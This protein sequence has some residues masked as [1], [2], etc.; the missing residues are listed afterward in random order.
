MQA[1]LDEYERANRFGFS[2][3]EVATAKSEAQSGA[4]SQFDSSDTTQDADYAT[5]YVANFLTG[6]AYPAADDAHTLASDMIDAVTPEALDL[7]FRARWHNTAPHVIISTPQDQESEMPSESDVLA[8]VAAIPDRELQPVRRANQ[9]P[10][11][12]MTA[13]AP[14]APDSQDHMISGWRRVLRSRRAHLPERR[15]GDRH[16]ER[17]R[18]GPG[19]VPS[20]K[21][22]GFVTRR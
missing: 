14:V 13:P 9:L 15:Q 6:D 20:G 5:Q 1:L 3:A 22:G 16:V 2:D 12:L 21:S 19:V 10:D 11:E 18:P 8:M 7:R 17:H 4:D